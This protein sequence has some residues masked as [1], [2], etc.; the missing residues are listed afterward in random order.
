MHLYS[1]N[2]QQRS[3][4]VSFQE[5]L[6]NSLPEDKGLYMPEYFPELKD[7]FFE[8]IENLTFQEIAFEV[9]DALLNEE[10]PAVKLRDI[11]D[12]AVNFPAP[13]AKLDDEKFVLELFHGPTLAFKDFGA[14]FMART[15][16]W[17]LQESPSDEEI[18]ILVATSGDTGGAVAQ[19]FL[20]V[21]GIK[22]TLLYPKGKV[23][24]L[25]EKQLTTVG[26]NVE[27][28]EVEGTFDDC[29]RMVKEAFLDKDLRARLKLSS[30]N[31]INISRLIPQS[32]YYFNAYAQ[33]KRQLSFDANKKLVFAVPSGNFGNLCGGLI[34]KRL[35]LPIQHIVASTNVND[36]VPKYLEGGAFEPKP[37][38][39]TLSNAMDVGNP[40]NFARL[41]AFY[42]TRPAA[43]ETELLNNIQQDISGARYTD[44]Q[45]TEAIKEVFD[46]YY[47]YTM[48]PHTAVG[49]LGLKDY[50]AQQKE[51][52]Y[53]VILA[54]AHPAKFVD[55]VEDTI[56]ESVKMP[57]SLQAIMQSEKNAT[58]IPADLEA[59]KSHL[60][61]G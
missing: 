36:I 48:C 3:N 55:T 20:N 26:N 50:Q 5:A 2:D 56:G 32:F 8:N 40:S 31:S 57:E 37:S 21:A 10:I 34:A 14:R 30:A 4:K 53:G 9:A 60:L 39:Q 46:K 42:Q 25:Q 33:L 29:Q 45:T 16:S 28:L 38:L 54:T 43:S 19:G 35:G 24:E 52:S 17:F 1:T 59:L 58:L 18:H 22:V 7:S 15:M 11:I 6:F 44:K 27:A 12:D 13:L 41:Q 61:K 49:Y 47:G 23:S 51:D